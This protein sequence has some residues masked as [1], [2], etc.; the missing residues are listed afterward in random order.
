MDE[1]DIESHRSTKLR[2]FKQGWPG[3]HSRLS[4]FD[5]KEYL[6]LVVNLIAVNPKVALKFAGHKEGRLNLHDGMRPPCVPPVSYEQFVECIHVLAESKTILKHI[7][8]FI[9]FEDFSKLYDCVANNSKRCMTP[10]TEKAFGIG[11][12]SNLSYLNHSCSPNCVLLGSPVGMYLI[13]LKDIQKGD[14]L[15]VSYTPNILMEFVAVQHYSLQL[16][17]DWGFCCQCETCR[18]NKLRPPQPNLFPRRTFE[19]M[20]KNEKLAAD[21]RVFERLH[22]SNDVDPAQIMEICE[23][24]LSEYGEILRKNPQ[25]M[26]VTSPFMPRRGTLVLTPKRVLTLFL[27]MLYPN[28]TFVCCNPASC[29]T[30]S[31]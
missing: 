14:E 5:N 23:Y 25:L 13:S 31:P 26:Y 12:Y 4:S 24:F 3:I 15:T 20:S 18:G 28:I 29:Q 30:K 8:P 6:Q 16:A 11:L 22:Y 27:G 21:F 9:R 17:E 7:I 10:V 2:F 19:V 1:K